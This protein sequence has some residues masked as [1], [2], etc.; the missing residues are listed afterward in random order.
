MKKAS[1]ICITAILAC[2]CLVWCVGFS[3]SSAGERFPESHPYYYAQSLASGGNRGGQA[4]PDSLSYSYSSP[5]SSRRSV[6]SRF[7]GG[8]VT[9]AFFGIISL[10]VGAIKS[11]FTGK[12]KDTED[13][14]PAE[15][16]PN[17]MKFVCTACG[18]YS[19]G[20]Y[21]TCP[22]CGAVGKM[23]R[24]SRKAGPQPQPSV[25]PQPGPRV[26]PTAQPP[27]NP[28]PQFDIPPLPRDYPVQFSSPVQQNDA[29]S[30]LW[31]TGPFA[32]QQ[33]EIQSQMSIGRATDNTIVIPGA[34]RSVSGY[35]CSVT[36]GGGEF[37]IRDDGSTNGTIV[38]DT[39]V[40]PAKQT[41]KLHPGDRV[42]LGS[43]DVSFS[44]QGTQ[45][46][47]PFSNMQVLY[48]CPN[49]FELTDH[50]PEKRMEVM[51]IEQ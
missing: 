47:D 18:Q 10:I 51:R 21:Q 43:G 7:S 16:E 32:G 37:Y 33:M 14:L 50:V 28:L 5:Y 25:N 26:P 1:I 48:G 45:K 46:E 22:H 20:W 44:V 27:I 34:F 36:A 42:Q 17:P 29:V 23:E 41:V 11:A 30:I 24:N 15:T 9:G 49:V 35:H 6:G 39:I 4:H 19:T 8:L 31:E 3:P 38:N 13:S 2:L 12:K 40:L